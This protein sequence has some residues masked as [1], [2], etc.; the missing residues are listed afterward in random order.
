MIGHGK[1]PISDMN[2]THTEQKDS[3]AEEIK[4]VLNE[5]LHHCYQVIDSISF[6]EFC[7]D[8]IYYNQEFRLSIP[9]IYGY[10]YVFKDPIH[11]NMEMHAYFCMPGFSTCVSIENY[12]S[13]YL[14][15]DGVTHAAALPMVVKGQSFPHTLSVVTKKSRLFKWLVMMEIYKILHGDQLERVHRNPLNQQIINNR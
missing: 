6:E 15:A 1:G 2:T 10:Q 5:Q 8:H 14:H 11:C 7:Q 4:H 12:Y 9:M 3:S 13:H